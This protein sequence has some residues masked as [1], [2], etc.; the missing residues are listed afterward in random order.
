MSSTSHRSIGQN[1]QVVHN[2]THV[3]LS[4][5]KQLWAAISCIWEGNHRSH[6]P[7]VRLQ[8]FTTYV[9]KA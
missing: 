5:T 2:F 3:P 4:L 7:C 9:L 6:W 8:W 1:G